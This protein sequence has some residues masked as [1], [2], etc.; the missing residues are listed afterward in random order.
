MSTFGFDHSKHIPTSG[1]TFGFD[2][3]EH[4]S[5]ETHGHTSLSGSWPQNC[6]VARFGAEGHMRRQV[7]GARTAPSSGSGGK[8]T[9]VVRV[10]GQEPRRR[11]V[12]G[13]RTQAMETTHIMHNL[14]IVDQNHNNCI[15]KE[16]PTCHNIRRQV[17][18][19]RTAPSSASGGK[20]TGVV[21][22]WGQEPRRRQVLEARTQASSGEG[23]VARMERSNGQRQ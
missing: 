9:G 7:L 3:S 22:V 6:A 16:P 1:T 2:H 14:Y 11:Q 13:A 21:R 19:A 18:G 20:D 8:D 10:W 5:S 17:L 23:H 4:R 15:S 12:L